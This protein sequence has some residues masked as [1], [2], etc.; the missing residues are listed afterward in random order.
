MADRKYDEVW[1]KDIDIGDQ[2]VFIYVVRI[3]MIAGLQIEDFSSAVALL[4]KELLD[5]FKRWKKSSMSKS[6]KQKKKGDQTS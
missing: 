3:S 4:F 1:F 2:Q 6:K 5:T